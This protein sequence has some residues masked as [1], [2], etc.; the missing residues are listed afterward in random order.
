M[1][2]KSWKKKN[3]EEKLCSVRH[4]SIQKKNVGQLDPPPPTAML[5]SLK[6]VGA[7]SK[8]CL[9][10]PLFSPQGQRENFSLTFCMPTLLLKELS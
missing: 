6:R 8:H 7:G 5:D 4:G 2:E 1:E 3:M 10:Y 9:N